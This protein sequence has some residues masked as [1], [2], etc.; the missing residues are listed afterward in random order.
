MNTEYSVVP[1]F[2]IGS[3]KTRV[4]QRKRSH[5]LTPDKPLLEPESVACGMVADMYLNGGLS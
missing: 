5:P 2:R 1:A 4:M 3:R